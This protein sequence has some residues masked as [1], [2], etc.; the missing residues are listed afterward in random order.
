MDFGGCWWFS[1]DFYWV[2]VVCKAKNTKKCCF[3]LQK[4][5]FFDKNQCSSE[6]T[7]SQQGKTA[8][9]RHFLW[10]LVDFEW[11]LVVFDW[12][13]VDFGGFLIDF[14]RF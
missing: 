7:S 6:A 11:I 13:L 10:N 8:A 14:G 1:D 5:H 3:C 9:G 2:Y 12:I 4:L